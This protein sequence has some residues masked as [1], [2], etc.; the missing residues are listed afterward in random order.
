M[1]S[2]EQDRRGTWRGRVREDMVRNE[3]HLVLV[4]ESP[5]G[6]RTIPY[7]GA[8]NYVVVDPE[9]LQSEIT[10]D[11]GLRISRGAATALH[12]AIGEYLGTRPNGSSDREAL[13]VERARTSQLLDVVCRPAAP[14][15]APT[16]VVALVQSLAPS[17]ATGPAERLWRLLEDAL[18]HKETLRLQVE[19]MRDELEAVRRARS[20]L[21]IDV[22]RVNQRIYDLK[23]A[24]AKVEPHPDS[25]AARSMSGKAIQN[26]AAEFREIL[27][28]YFPDGYTNQSNGIE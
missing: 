12:Q 18:Q 15:P 19:E 23:E 7:W 6:T 24:F 27:Q 20:T 3:L 17:A 14:A 16:D 25:P 22:M 1:T 2:A 28:G 9:I 5:N 26:I 11:I 21:S 4:N 10:P 13:L 8:G